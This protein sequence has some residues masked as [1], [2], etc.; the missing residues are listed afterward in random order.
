MIRLAGDGEHRW[1]L[2]VLSTHK[3]S[4]VDTAGRLA[5]MEMTFPRGASP[6]LHTHP[7]DETFYVLDG[8]VLAWEG[9]NAPVR[10]GP[11]GLLCA[12]AGTAHSFR[13]ESETARMLIL[14]TASGIEDFVRALSVPAESPT[15]PPADA[16]RPTPEER[17]AAEAAHEQIFVGPPP[18]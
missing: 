5:V 12:T 6:P 3:V 2:G 4:G 11:G 17:A 16:W 8:E 15:L 18:G 1:F 10:L 13:V 7:Q 9:A 14:S